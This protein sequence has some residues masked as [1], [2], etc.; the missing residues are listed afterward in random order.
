[1]KSSYPEKHINEIRHFL[2]KL[3]SIQSDKNISSDISKTEELLTNLEELIKEEIKAE[4][5]YRRIVENMQDMYFRADLEGNLIMVSPSIKNILGYTPEEAIGNKIA[6]NFYA[7]PEKRLE[8]LD[9]LKEKGEANNYEVN[10]ISKDGRIVPILSNSHFIY[11]KKG[12][13]TSIEGTITDIT[14]RKKAEHALKESEEKFRTLTNQLPVGVYRTT[15]DGYF[16]YFNPALAEMLGYEEKELKQIAVPELYKDGKDREDGIQYLKKHPEGI[17]QREIQL[18]T[19]QGSVIIVNDHINTVLDDDGNIKYFD[20]VLEDI[21]ERKRTEQA[22]KESEEKFRQLAQTTSTAIMVY[23]GNKWVYANP[24]AERISGYSQEQ[25]KTKNFWEFVAPEYQEMIKQRGQK[26]QKKE[27]VPTGYEFKIITKEGRQR[28]VYL[29]GSVMEY[30]GKPAGLISVID[31]T[32]MKNTEKAL[33]EK[34]KKLQA[35]EEKLKATNNALKEINKELEKQKEEL[36]IAKNEAEENAAKRNSLLEAIPDMIFVFDKDGY[37][38]DYHAEKREFLYKQPENFLGKKVDEVLPSYLV[39]LTYEKIEK[40]LTTGNVEEYEYELKLRNK[41]FVFESRMVMLNQNSTLAI[42]RDITETKEAREELIKAKEKAEESDR[43]K[44]AFLANM[45]HE[46]RTPVN[47]I[48][49]FTQLLRDQE[50][51]QEEQEEFFDIIDLNSSQLLQII[52][53]IIDISKIEANQLNINE[54]TF[55]LNKL[56]DELYNSYELEL[57]QNNKTHLSVE[58]HKGLTEGEDKIKTDA[59][60]LKQVMSNLLTN[61]AKF[62]EKG[63]IDFGYKLTDGNEFLFFVKD[64]GIGI[65]EDKQK[66]IFDHFRRAHETRASKYG[67][68]GLGLSIS[69]RLV[70]M[71]GGKIWVESK[72]NEGANFFFTLTIQRMK[73]SPESEKENKTTKSYEWDQEKILVVE[74]DPFCQKFIRELL[75]STQAELKF[76]NN[77]ADALKIFRANPDVSIILMDIKLPDKDGL[78]LTSKIRELNKEVPIIAT[79]AYAMEND[80]K[81]AIE[82]GCNEYLSKPLNKKT[83]LQT[84][85]KYL[86]K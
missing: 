65:P 62:T 26:R 13:P 77:G 63:T 69:K 43:L 73:T 2:S 70:E 78:E 24:A 36:E 67:G 11:D 86:N 47:G 5:K 71:L 60:R 15:R 68:T 22:L 79:T 35:A 39:N 52:N 75:K 23:Q 44:S 54:Q 27:T 9:I 32:E 83:L 19:K 4:N 82:S 40:V 85:S 81:T 53:D 55:S 29:E 18:I 42:V 1:M 20:G 45:S 76:A 74:D 84:I 21:T 7:D 46:I 8:L 38:I 56:M 34:N 48:V 6:E 28:W 59:I 41:K 50:Y 57:Q 30:Q 51:S 17:T 31:I 12:N 72:E 80:K 16:I 33:K 10:L 49:G 58:L 37:I 64:T 14:K 25:L 3:Q 61:A 66:V